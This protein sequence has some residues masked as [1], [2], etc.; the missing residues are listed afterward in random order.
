MGQPWV[1]AES[2]LKLAI[3]TDLVTPNATPGDFVAIACE[4]P[5]LSFDTPVTEIEL[6][7]GQPGAAPERIIGTRKG[8]LTFRVPLEGFK[9]GFS[10]TTENPGDAGVI[11]PWFVLAANIM[12]CDISNL[13]GATLSD[14]NTAFW[15]GAFIRLGFG[16][17]ADAVASAL[18][19][20]ITVDAGKGANYVPGEFVMS[21][22]GTSATALQKGFVKSIA[23]D[24]LTL[25]EDAA[26]IVNDN[27]AEMFGTT[28]AYVSSDQPRPL[29]AT[30]V[31]SS[32]AAYGYILTGLVAEGFKIGLDSSETPVIEFS[33]RFADYQADSTIG[34]LAVPASYPH[35]APIV[36]TNNGRVTIAGAMT[37]G[38]ENVSF[39]FACTLSERK[40]HAAPQ[41]I[42][43]IIVTKRVARVT[44][45]VPHDST[46]AIYN[47]IGGG[48]TKG[49]HKWQSFL[50]RGVSQSIGVETGAGAGSTFA[51]LVPAGKLVAVPQLTESDGLL[52]YQLT[53]EAS[54]Y[55]GDGSSTAPGNTVARLALA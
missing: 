44:A 6:L 9:D 26:T 31:G 7:T 54:T 8:T 42:S 18:A 28:T 12:G 24:V 32:S 41:G 1:T 37:C 19:G 52:A 45:T 20:A 55:T 23:G 53:L 11:P 5:T 46:D 27:A 33:Y 49:D 25:F 51:A 16:Y 47:A 22:L 17:D 30:Y 14:K 39:E 35:I 40:C 36:G 15:K 21:G 50:Q 34:G 48:A 2:S 13:A 29:T 38:L 10:P 43:D 4:S 3:Q